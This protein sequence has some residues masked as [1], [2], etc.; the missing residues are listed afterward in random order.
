M[1]NISKFICAKDFEN[2]CKNDKCSDWL[3]YKYPKNILQNS[4]FFKGMEFKKYI[5]TELQKKVNYPLQKLCSF[6]ENKMSTEER[7]VEFEKT[8]LAITDGLPVLYSPYI[9]CNKDKICGIPDLLIRNDFFNSLFLT[10]YKFLNTTQ[11]YYIPI[12]ITYMSMQLD[13]NNNYILNRELV[14]YYKNNLYL[15]SVI[16]RNNF[17]I[18]PDRSYI[19][20]KNFLQTNKPFHINFYTYDKEIKLQYLAGLEW[21]KKIKMLED[22]TT[23]MELYPEIYPNMKVDSC[24]QKEKKEISDKI[25]EITS[26]FYCGFKNREYA[27]EQN[28]YDIYDKRLNADIL[29]YQ[30]FK[31][32]E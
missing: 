22:N 18:F 11:K 28:I 3:K 2:F 4:L 29:K 27:Y 30:N 7:K 9:H 5:I 6:Y 1:K 16:L 26:I 25:G 21:V 15:Y 10:D 13:V 24:Y 17:G 20:S 32:K 12:E 31:K 8:V 14:S 23:G 19:I